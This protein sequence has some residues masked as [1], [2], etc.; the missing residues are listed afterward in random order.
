MLKIEHHQQEEVG[1]NLAG[2]L[3]LSLEFV[4]VLFSFFGW[5]FY[6]FPGWFFFKLKIKMIFI[7]SQNF[8]FFSLLFKM[9]E[10]KKKKKKKKNDT[11]IFLPKG[12]QGDD[13]KII[14]SF[15]ENCEEK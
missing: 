11:R 5:S 3:C 15:K 10:K 9:G 1:V 13:F 14:I 2:T 6:L 7:F 8:V 4:A 12:Q